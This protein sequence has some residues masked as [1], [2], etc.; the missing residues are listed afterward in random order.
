MNGYPTP[1]SG[2]GWGFG[3]YL[4]YGLVP[5]AVIGAVAGAALHPGP[6]YVQTSLGYQTLRTAAFG[7][8]VGTAAV[9]IMHLG[10]R[11]GV[12]PTA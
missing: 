10:L 4:K 3:P 2:P 9:G 5:G 7:A 1:Y 11:M 6:Q 8:I 12:I